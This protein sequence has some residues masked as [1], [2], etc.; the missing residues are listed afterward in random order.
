MK[1]IRIVS[2]RQLFAQ[3][4]RKGLRRIGL[5]TV[6]IFSIILIW[7]AV[8]RF[9]GIPIWLIPAPSDIMLSMVLRYNLYLES[10]Y[11]TFYETMYGFLL[12]SVVGV[13]LAIAFAY[14][15]FIRSILNPIVIAINSI[16]KIAIGPLIVIWF[17]IGVYSKIAMS[18]IMSFFPIVI[19]V[20]MGLEQIN[21]NFIE[22]SRSLQA[23][24]MQTFTK[25][26]LPH[27]IP[28]LMEALKI[29][30]PLAIIGAVLG[31]FLAGRGARLSDPSRNELFSICG[32][33]CSTITHNHNVDRSLQINRYYIQK[34]Y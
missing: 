4:V 15:N 9:M 31:E 12:G 32:L 21:P 18:F 10:M 29:S 13:A 22:L 17:G 20:L 23:S 7:E 8:V 14:S 30:L 5:I 1:V 34:G 26:R 6:Y 33:I 16:P 2:L 24:T 27:S 3:Q 25:I 28:F 11:V 19:N